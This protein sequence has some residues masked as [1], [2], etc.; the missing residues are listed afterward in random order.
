MISTVLSHLALFLTLL[1]AMGFILSF[2]PDGWNSPVVTGQAPPP[3]DDFSLTTV[4]GKRVAMFGG[5]T[6]SSIYSDDLYIVDL[7][8]HSVVSV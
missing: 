5:S 6:P 3:C 2:P 4:G 7:E 1:C 8:R